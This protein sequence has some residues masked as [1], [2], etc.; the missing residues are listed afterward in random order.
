MALTL[1]EFDETDYAA[2]AALYNRCRPEVPQSEASLRAF[3]SLYRDDRL[4]SL[5]AFT[6]G[7]L[8]GAVWAYT[9]LLG[10][11]HVRFGIVA[12]PEADAELP[13][14]LYRAAVTGLE[15]Q[16]PAALTTRVR[17]DWPDWLDFYEARGFAETE[18]VWEARLE[19]ADFT[20]APYKWALARTAASGV[21]IRTLAELPTDETTQRLIYQA[22]TEF[23]SDMPFS[24]TP[25]IWPFEVWQARYWHNP[26]RRP[27]S[28]FLAFR[29]TELI[30]LS[31]LRVGA[32]PDWLRTGLTGV[33]LEH[34]N[35]GVALALKVRAAQ[36]AQAAGFTTITAQNHAV[37]RPIIAI[38]EALGFIR[39]PAWVG[40]K[41]AF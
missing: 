7:E 39:E 12:A 31:E 6:E 33:K 14:T 38:N 17:Q 3:D 13:E 28:F 30:G 16:R 35:Q 2:F 22:L 34:R 8:I 19:L 29:G 23:W 15:P 1:R 4:L 26:V 27:E 24:E 36:V 10:D 20:A 41:R 40:L 5:L 11:R 37:N 21:V 18:R 9:D 25:N 32:A